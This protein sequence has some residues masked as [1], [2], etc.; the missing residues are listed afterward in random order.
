[1]TGDFPSQKASNADF[2][3]FFYVGPHKLLHKQ[4]NDRRCELHD[5]YVTSS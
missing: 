1:M 5:F 3:V 4:S 2:D